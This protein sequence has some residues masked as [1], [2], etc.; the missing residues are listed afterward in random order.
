VE[1]Y[2]K[3]TTQPELPRHPTTPTLLVTPLLVLLRS[4]IIRM[5]RPLILPARLP[6]L[7]YLYTWRG[8]V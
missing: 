3:M 8:S 5:E 4:T 6:P 1:S 7:D 2:D